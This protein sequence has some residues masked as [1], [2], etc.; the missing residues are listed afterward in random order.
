M[1]YAMLLV[2]FCSWAVAALPPV[3]VRYAGVDGK[4]RIFVAGT[5]DS[6]ILTASDGALQTH[7]AHG[8]C[9]AFGFHNT[10]TVPCTDIFVL[11]LDSTGTKVEAATYLGG[12]G[13][14][15]LY[16]F[17]VNTDGTVTVALQSQ[18]KVIPGVVQS[19]ELLG[20]VVIRLN[21][22]LQKTT[23]VTSMQGSTIQDVAAGSD[24]TTYVSLR[25]CVSPDFCSGR[26]IRIN[27][28][29]SQRWSSIVAEGQGSS[30][31][32]VSPDGSTVWIAAVGP[33]GLTVSVLDAEK[34]DSLR[35]D[36][37]PVAANDVRAVQVTKAGAVL[38][39]A[40][41]ETPSL[42]AVDKELRVLRRLDFGSELN[43]LE[44]LG[45]DT[46][47]TFGAGPYRVKTTAT[48]IQRCA[49]NINT[50]FVVDW[51]SSTGEI[52]FGTYVPIA[53]SAIATG[54]G[55]SL[56]SFEPSKVRIDDL[57]TLP[58]QAICIDAS[59]L[60]FGMRLVDLTSP[61]AGMR[62]AP[63]EFV[64]ISGSGV[65]PLQ[66]VRVVMDGTRASAPKQLEGTRVLFDGEAAALVS[67]AEN[68]IVAQVPYAVGERSYTKLRVEVGG[69]TTDERT[70]QVVR[71]QPVAISG[72]AGRAG[73]NN[74]VFNA[75]FGL[76]SVL[77]PARRGDVVSVFLS[78]AGRLEG[79]VDESLALRDP[80]PTLGSTVAA[81]ISGAGRQTVEFAG[82]VAGQLPGLVQVNI[83][84]APEF[85]YHGRMQLEIQIGG[86]ENKT[87]VELWVE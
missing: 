71:A 56:L 42:V 50:Q 67:V 36:Y 77:H 28:D 16:G 6:D 7:Y 39:I 57:S 81:Y 45:G 59:V 12:V 40:G 14:E 44:L 43:G 79:I 60:N 10:S 86:T 83:R 41:P 47:R 19:S 58:E 26:V 29:G 2:L 5:L 3:Q 25:G 34:G 65:G 17:K 11:R 53:A 38:A 66:E 51:N 49:V 87:L 75:D 52:P 72:A 22:D 80:V 64:T 85:P 31:L 54:Y 27:S 74:A 55:N 21:S 62:V 68:R 30:K 82:G 15:V 1:K 35:R 23:S 8:D 20:A 84:I 46:V 4:G 18:S 24:G 63:G 48:S 33:A 70:F 37:I 69:Q 78:G 76:N 32:S 61:E 73:Y 13:S 9:I